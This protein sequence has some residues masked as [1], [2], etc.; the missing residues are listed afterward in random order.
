VPASLIALRHQHIS[1]G[2]ARL[3]G[4]FDG[5]NLADRRR[6]DRV[7]SRDRLSRFPAKER[8]N[9]HALGQA[10]LE[11]LLDA[12]V[13]HKVDAKGPVGQRADAPNL[14]QRLVG[15][16]PEAPQHPQTTSSA[17]GCDQ[18]GVGVVAGHAGLDNRMSDAENVTQ[19]GVKH[20]PLLILTRPKRCHVAGNLAISS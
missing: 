2:V 3:H 6:A 1:A 20:M 11:G 5:R 13:Q 19:A 16:P 17:D 10:S 8:E 14:G 9:R 7:C 12:Q 15:R 18:I 4:L